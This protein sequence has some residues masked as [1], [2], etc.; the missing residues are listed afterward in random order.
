MRKMSRTLAVVAFLAVN[1]LFAANSAQ[2]AQDLNVDNLGG[3][4]VVWCDGCWFW[5]CNCPVS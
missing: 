2:A 4:I 3:I 5:N 1:S